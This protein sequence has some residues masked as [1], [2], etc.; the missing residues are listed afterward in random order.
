MDFKNLVLI[1][2]VKDFKIV[3]EIVQEVWKLA[4]FMMSLSIKDGSIAINC[5]LHAFAISWRAIECLDLRRG[6]SQRTSTFKEIEIFIILK[7]KIGFE[8]RKLKEKKSNFCHWKQ[9]TLL[10]WQK[11]RFNLV[12]TTTRHPWV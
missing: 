7:R 10:F 11:F 6:C 4:R 8:L 2:F 12:T 9:K 5:H 3:V 1:K